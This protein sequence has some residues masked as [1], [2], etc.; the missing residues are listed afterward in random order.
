[1]NPDSE[2]RS[3][4]FIKE[5]ETTEGPRENPQEGTKLIFDHVLEY[6]L[7]NSVRQAYRIYSTMDGWGSLNRREK[8]TLLLFPFAAPTMIRC[9]AILIIRDWRLLQRLL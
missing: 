6:C 1:M 8:S 3:A 4:A 7:V 2:Q 9:G 5:K